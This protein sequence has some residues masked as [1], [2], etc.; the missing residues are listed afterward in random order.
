MDKGQQLQEV[1]KLFSNKWTMDVFM[2]FDGLEG[3]TTYTLLKN[4]ILG[5][6]EKML[7]QTLRKLEF[8]QG[9]LNRKFYPGMPPHS[10]YWLSDK[11]SAL[12]PIIKELQEWGEFV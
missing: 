8:E 9:L 11:G 2:Q 7:S 12:M 5:I 3:R 10:E 6:S 4:H 1:L